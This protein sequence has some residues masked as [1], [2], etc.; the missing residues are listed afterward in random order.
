M[1]TASLAGRPLEEVL[2]R[3]LALGFGA[4]EVLGFEGERHSQGDLCGFAFAER[5]TADVERLR[6]L[7]AGYG[8]ISVHAPFILAPL[9]TAN[10]GIAREVRRQVGACIRGMAAVGGSACTVHLNGMPFKTPAE[11]RHEAVLVLRSLGD[12]GVEAG[13][14]VVAL[15][16][17][18]PN[19]EEEFC[20]LLETVGHPCV[21]ACIDTGH[22]V[23]YY[24]GGERGT[25]AGVEHHNGILNRMVARLG[26]KV[27]LFHVHDNRR[28]DFRDH[29]APGRGIIDWERL[30]ATVRRHCGDAP[31]LLELEE[32]DF[33]DAL[34]EGAACLRS[35]A[36]AG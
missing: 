5:P 21:G 27:A 17:G 13:G 1:S 33:E 30:L 36:A 25:Q 29:R 10:P 11:W 9:L 35:A 15:E 22:I 12:A 23:H 20:S 26:A 32:P 18:F 24:P 2:Q 7:L 28:E 3:G 14:V 16:T 19:S 8:R 34:R 6:G 31:M 4:V